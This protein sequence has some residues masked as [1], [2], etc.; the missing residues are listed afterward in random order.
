MRRLLLII[1]VTTVVLPAVAHASGKTTEKVAKPP[2]TRPVQKDSPAVPAAAH[3]ATPVKREVAPKAGHTAAAVTSASAKP[4]AAPVAAV[5]QAVAAAPPAPTTTGETLE[6]IVARV[7][8]RLGTE[9][10]RPARR[11]AAAPAPALPERVTLVWRPAIVWPTELAPRAPEVSAS[12][13]GRVTLA[14]DDESR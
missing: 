3:A 6:E 13:A 1:A 4:A 5:P 8:R 12:D 10:A 14:W 11:V 9:V 7:R 2:A